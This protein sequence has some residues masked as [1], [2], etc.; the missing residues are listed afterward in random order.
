MA[1]DGAS[2]NRARPTLPVGERRWCDRA[3]DVK[4]PKL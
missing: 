3:A 2:D 4:A 1:H